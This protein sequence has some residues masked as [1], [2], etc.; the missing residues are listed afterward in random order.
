MEHEINILYP[1]KKRSQDKLSI[2]F[3]NICGLN[4]NQGVAVEMTERKNKA[5]LYYI[6]RSF[7]EKEL[8][9]TTTT[10]YKTCPRL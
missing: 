6:K 8:T 4:N 7:M 3:L 10:S 2:I 9:S 5:G 1:K